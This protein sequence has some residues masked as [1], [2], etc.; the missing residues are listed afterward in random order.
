MPRVTYDYIRNLDP[1]ALGKMSKSQMKD[2]LRKIRVKT[3]T[4]IEQ[5][6]DVNVYSPAKEKFE[7]SANASKSLKKMTRNEMMREVFQHQNFHNAKTS[8]VAG[9]R[10]VATQQDK[11]LFGVRA[12]G[13]PK[14]R[15]SPAQRARFWS[16]YDEFL[17]TYKDAYARFG[18][19][20]I[21]Q[22]LAEMQIKEKIKTIGEIN[23]ED[24][25]TLLSML[26]KSQEDEEED[27]EYDDANVFSGRGTY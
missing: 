26:E 11:M 25:D 16:L 2:L 13:R 19:Q 15:M 10:N 1:N 4:R 21:F 9:A 7:S 27:Y 14:Y 22:N 20:A 5:L 17:R 24:F 6:N 12:S 18:Y 8:T 3:Q 23:T